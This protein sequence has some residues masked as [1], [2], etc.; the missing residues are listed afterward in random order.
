MN[1][2]V[3]FSK[4]IQFNT[5]LNK[6]T[7]ISLEHTLMAD[8]NSCVKGDLIVSG[9][10]KQTLASQIDNS[11]SYKIPVDIEVDEKYDLTNLI[12]DI[13]DF[14]YEVLDNN[15][16]KVNIDLILDKLELKKEEVKE[17]K[18][19]EDELISVDDLFLEKEDL[20]KL[21]IPD[22]EIE[23]LDFDERLNS[24][25]EEY[26]NRVEEEKREIKDDDELGTELNVF[27]ESAENIDENIDFSKALDSKDDKFSNNIEEVQNNIEG[28]SCDGE[29]EIK[30]IEDTTSESLFSNL[31][32]NET[33]ST[34]SIY[35]VR[36]N[37]NLEDIMSKYKITREKLEEYN[38]LSEIKTGFKLII[39][40]CNE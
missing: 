39:P 12:I 20:K 15:K 36:E 17:D 34:Y 16:L 27:N 25:I 9:T 40:T 7:S 14:T 11:F 1:E 33:Y 4:E 38:N 5:M 24:S 13:D 28:D 19:D 18:Q 6:I 37:D 21:E 35:I 29:E 8:E 32:T 23:T 31:S 2:I 26:K 3:S 30:K 22:S 10:Y